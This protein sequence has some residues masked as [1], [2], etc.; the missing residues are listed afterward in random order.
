MQHCAWPSPETS[1]ILAPTNHFDVDGTIEKV[2]NSAFAIDHSKMLEH[3]A[4]IISN[5]DDALSTL[6]HRVSPEFQKI[7][8][9]AGLI[10]SKGMG[11]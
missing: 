2:L 3:V 10:I 1:S 6:L 11:N 5:S 8:Q 7:Y 4:N 9:Q